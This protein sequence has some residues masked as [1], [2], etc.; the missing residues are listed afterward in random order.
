[1]RYLEELTLEELLHIGELIRC[2]DL[3]IIKDE[4]HNPR[5]VVE[6]YLSGIFVIPYFN[7][8]EDE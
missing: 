3:N 4:L 6:S 1:M 2:F 7:N 5:F 8:E